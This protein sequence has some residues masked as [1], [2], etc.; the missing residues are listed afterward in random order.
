MASY[1]G[2]WGILT[3]LT[4]STDHPSMVSFRGFGVEE[5]RRRM[6]AQPSH[7]VLLAATS[8]HTDINESLMDKVSYMGSYSFE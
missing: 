7:W 8:K 2:L 5:S 4:E 6:L 3:R 1:V